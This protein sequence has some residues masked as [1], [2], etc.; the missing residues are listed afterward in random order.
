MARHNDANVSR[1]WRCTGWAPVMAKPRGTDGSLL[2]SL[3]W[4]LAALAFALAPHG[5]YLPIWITAAFLV[6]STWRYVIE[7]RRRPLP[8][9]GL[10]ALLAMICSNK[11]RYAFSCFTRP[12]SSGEAD[13]GTPRAL[14][15]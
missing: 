7:K 5:Q 10:R 6:C 14:T 4:T 9:T 12:F 3:P 13:C 2:A 8:S 15:P 11:T 1:H